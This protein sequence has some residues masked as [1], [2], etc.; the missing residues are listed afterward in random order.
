MSSASGEIAFDVFRSRLVR[1]LVCF[2]KQKICLLCL[3]PGEILVNRMN[4]VVMW[5]S[6]HAFEVEHP[7]RG[8]DP[9]SE[10]DFRWSPDDGF[11]IKNLTRTGYIS[12][13][14]P[15]KELPKIPFPESVI[16]AHYND[17]CAQNETHPIAIRPAPD[18]HPCPSEIA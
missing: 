6:E 17:R 9:I 10:I 7:I 13:A 11:A 4:I 2:R 12:D 18:R 15:A 5:G 16:V 1:L 8:C 3:N 14:T